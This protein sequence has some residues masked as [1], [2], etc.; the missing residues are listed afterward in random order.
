MH[1]HLLEC[2]REFPVL[3]IHGQHHSRLERGVTH[4]DHHFAL[5]KF[6]T[7]PGASSDVDLVCAD[8]HVLLLESIWSTLDVLA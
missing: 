8:A 4:L 7:V 2:R 6:C 1:L 5:V 3:W